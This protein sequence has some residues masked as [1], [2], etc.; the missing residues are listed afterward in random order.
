MCTKTGAVVGEHGLS[1]EVSVDRCRLSE[2]EGIMRCLDIGTALP[3]C[4]LSS[5]KLMLME[6]V[7]KI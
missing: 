2:R 3:L 4:H 7:K 5:Q 1:Y 6:L